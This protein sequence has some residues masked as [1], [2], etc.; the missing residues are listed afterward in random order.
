MFHYLL[1][2]KLLKWIKKRCLKE[3]TEKKMNKSP[4]EKD[5]RLECAAQT[6]L[7]Y[8]YLEMGKLL[9]YLLS[10]ACQSEREH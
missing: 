6:S 7:F 3:S 2:R 9:R 1:Y 10:S 4:W 5:Y 8:E